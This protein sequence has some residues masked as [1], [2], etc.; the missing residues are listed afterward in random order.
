MLQIE[1]IEKDT[2]QEK[3]AIEEQR[4]AGGTIYYP[5]LTLKRKRY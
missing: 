5:R 4:S 1:E 3:E 2:R